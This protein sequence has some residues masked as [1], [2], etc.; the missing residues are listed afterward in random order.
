MLWYVTRY[1]K[2]KDQIERTRVSIYLYSGRYHIW[3]QY[4]TDKEM[5]NFINLSIEP[6]SHVLDM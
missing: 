5:K 4:M 3:I 2:K 6:I 1:L